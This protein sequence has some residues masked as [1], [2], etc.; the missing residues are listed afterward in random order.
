MCDEGGAAV[1]I[2][3]LDGIA[4]S[5]RKRQM[6]MIPAIRHGM[7]ACV[8]ASA[9]AQCAQCWSAWPGHVELQVGGTDLD[10]FCEAYAYATKITVR[11]HCGAASPAITRAYVV[12]T[13]RT[14]AAAR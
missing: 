6:H 1:M 13:V 8:Y 5:D 12:R 2:W 10:L 7:I 4:G 9:C 14:M 11:Q 3:T